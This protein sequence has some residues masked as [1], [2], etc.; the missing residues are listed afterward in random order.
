VR[1]DLAKSNQLGSVGTFG[2]SGAATTNVIMDPQEKLVAIL[3]AQHMPF[4]ENNLFGTFG[5]LTYQALVE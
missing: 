3:M 4:N 5:A 2:W 1:L